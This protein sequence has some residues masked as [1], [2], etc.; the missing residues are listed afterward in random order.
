MHWKELEP[1]IKFG[2]LVHALRQQDCL[3]ALRVLANLMLGVRIYALQS[4]VETVRSHVDSDPKE[5]GGLLLGQVWQQKKNVQNPAG[6]LTILVEAIP[7][8]DYRNTSVSLEMGTDVWS[9]VNERLSAENIVVGWYHSHP[10]LGAF[11]SDTDRK[12][13]RAFF[14]HYY[15]LGWVIDPIRDVQRVFVGKDSKEYQPS[16]LEINHGL[17]MA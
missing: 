1:D 5:V 4:C 14:N 3:S 16:I 15:S 17:E 11:F 10:N 6:A 12:T 2:T 8:V 13:Q 7:S 9:Q